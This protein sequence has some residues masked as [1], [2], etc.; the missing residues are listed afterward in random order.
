MASELRVNTLKDAAGNNSIAT[1]Y[2]ANGSA[3]VWVNFD[4]TASGAAARDSFGVSSMDDNGTG[5]YDVNLSSAMSNANY[6]VV[7]GQGR[8]NEG[9]YSGQ[10]EISVATVA[11]TSLQVF[12][13]TVASAKADYSYNA[14]AFLGDLA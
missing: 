14:I 3:K 10:Y 1:S 11:T 7:V 2:V 13:N 6:A 8:Y 5:D 9:S 12:S 4:G